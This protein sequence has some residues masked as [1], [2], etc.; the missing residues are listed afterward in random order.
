MFPRLPVGSR[1]LCELFSDDIVF[2]VPSFQRPFAWGPEEALQ[3][4]DDVSRAAGIDAPD[5]GEPAYFLGTLLLLTEPG[6]D[7]PGPREPNGEEGSVPAVAGSRRTYIVIDG[8]QRLTT[9]TMLFSILRDLG[10]GQAQPRLA[11]LISVLDS[12]SAEDG[13]AVVDFRLTLNGVDR[14]LYRRYV[15]RQGGTIAIPDGEGGEEDAGTARVLEVRDA[16]A[17]TLS[18]L[19]AGQRDALATYLMERC[20]VV[21]TLS[22]DID[23][24]HQLFIVLN[25]RG[26]PLGRNDIIKVEVLGGL[27]PQE[28]DYARRRWDS[29]EQLL[30]VDFEAFFGHLKAVHGRRRATVVTGLRSLIAEAGGAR[31]F[32]DEVMIPYARIFARIRDCRDT[33]PAEGDELARRLYYLGRLRGEE[34]VPAVMVAM[35]K[36][37]GNP[38]RALDLVAAIDRLAHLMRI[39]CQGGGRRVTRFN[40]ITLAIA[41]GKVV[42]GTADIFQLNREELR[43][44]K[45]N[46]RNLHRRNPPVCKLLLLR[47]NDHVQGSIAARDP[48]D[49]S[50]EHILPV[51]PSATSNWRVLFPEPEQ[52]EAA[53]QCLGNLTLL[54]ER[55]ND[56]ARNRDFDDKRSL[57]AEHFRSG[58]MLEIVHDVVTAAQWTYDVVAAREL[59]MLE[60][61][62]AVIGLE[63]GDA[64]M[65]A[66]EDGKGA[67][68]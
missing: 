4:L 61:L 1:V 21:I 64:A 47:I 53:T 24:A 35:R 29:A 34:W 19:S 37:A 5:S 7:V 16:L 38:D 31:L 43:N 39:Q 12:E 11:P 40:Q 33:P 57:I 14:A 23:Q 44:A 51:R 58:P 9:L 10:A 20:H 26:K 48:K 27:S 65:G 56:R 63:L 25:D 15:Q 67:A 17:A 13:L 32:I 52:R 2:S 45:F 28:S 42:D 3:L 50:V 49:L 30:G 60:A 59:R 8:Q 55:L 18:Q 66:R 54:P 22:H 62:S 6:N 41:S 68:E 36:Y 46:L